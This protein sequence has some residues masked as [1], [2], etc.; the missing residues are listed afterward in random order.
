MRATLIAWRTRRIFPSEGIPEERE[1]KR[2]HETIVKIGRCTRVAIPVG[3]ALVACAVF[4]ASP[5]PD[6]PRFLAPTGKPL[7]AATADVSGGVAVLIGAGDIGDCG[8]EGA[9]KTA[10][11]VERQLAGETAPTWVFTLGDNAY[12]YGS[13]SNFADCYEPHWGRFKAITRPVPGNHD[14]KNGYWFLGRTTS[15]G[16]AEPFFRYFD[17][18]PG[19]AGDPG[20]GWYRY[21]HGRWD[22]FALNTRKRHGVDRDS[23]QWRWLA[24]ELAASQAECS[25]AYLHHPRFSTGKHGDDER[26][27]GTWQLLAQYGID[28]LLAGHEHN[29]QRF[30]PQDDAGHPD[31]AGMRQFVV[32][33]GGTHLT[34][35][36]TR[37]AGALERW[38]RADFGVLELT[39]RPD[40]Y[41]WAFVTAD[42]SV[43]DSGSSACQNRARPD[44]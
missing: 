17:A 8:S 28:V 25:L 3:A 1:R 44:R 16:H 4:A 36:S 27:R 15:L 5:G 32:G 41:D 19:Q 37:T 35:G 9:E 12:P 13:E 22:V 34:T 10:R 43:W 7:N 29:Y 33:S 21:R 39:L 23:A 42:G 24:A 38:N 14:Y 20:D 11:L 40:G 31:A 2:R 18:F 26:M 30:G 6:E